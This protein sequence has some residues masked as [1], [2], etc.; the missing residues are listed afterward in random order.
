M[1][2]RDLGPSDLYRLPNAL[3]L[4]AYPRSGT[5]LVRVILAHCFGVATSSIYNEEEV[6]PDWVAL[7]RQF[8]ACDGAALAAAHG[9]SVVYKTHDRADPEL[10]GVPTLV[11]V[12]HPA[13]TFAS[14]ADFYR[15][16]HEMQYSLDQLIAGRHLWGDWSAWVR[17]YLADS[18]NPA[19]W[20]RYESV[21]ADLPAA[22]AAIA[23]HTGLMVRQATI[24]TFADL[25]AIAPHIFVSARPSPP[26]E[27]LDPEL[28][29]RH[30]S[31][32]SA[33]GYL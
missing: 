9:G 23:E 4:A 11:V 10:S 3:R 18:A 2:D 28:V 20:L 1:S 17:S 8:D 32:M 29:R 26:R 27:A 16:H 25:R 5:S 24:P 6:A 13:A 21:L 14:L 15:Q 19:L 12:R 31:I 33:L 22:L 30:G 7:M